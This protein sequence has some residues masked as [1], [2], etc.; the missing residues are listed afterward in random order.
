MLA[1]NQ[2][3]VVSKYP[4]SSNPQQLPTPVSF[5]EATPFNEKLLWFQIITGI[6]FVRKFLSL[7][8]A[9]LYLT[10]DAIAMIFHSSE[11]MNTYIHSHKKP[12][13]LL[14]SSLW[15]EAGLKKKK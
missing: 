15:R 11:N 6:T 3:Q 10:W 1:Q 7:A 12:G 8:V 9:E 13:I 5:D 2:L 4:G 14:N